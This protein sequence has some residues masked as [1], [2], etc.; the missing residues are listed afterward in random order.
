MGSGCSC[1]PQFH[2]AVGCQPWKEPDKLERIQ[3]HVTQDTNGS[4][5][6]SFSCAHMVHSAAIKHSLLCEL[7]DHGLGPIATLVFSE[8][9]RLERVAP[10]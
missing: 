9:M 7:K 2:I 4:S 5:T 1:A 10:I 8:T 6:Q 3:D